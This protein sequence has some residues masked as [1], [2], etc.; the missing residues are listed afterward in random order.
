M[1]EPVTLPVDRAYL[2]T[3]CMTITDSATACPAC[4]ESALLGVWRIIPTEKPILR[5]TSQ[6]R[7]PQSFYRPVQIGSCLLAEKV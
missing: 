4:T 5:V 7:A 2:C 1:R 3:S 6:K